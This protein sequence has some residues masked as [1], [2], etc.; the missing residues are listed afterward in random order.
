MLHRY[1]KNKVDQKPGWN[2]NMLKWCLQEARKH[3][4]KPQD[5][6]GGFV[7]DEM[8]IQVLMRNKI[9]ENF[10]LQQSATCVHD[11][12]NSNSGVLFSFF[13]SSSLYPGDTHVRGAGIRL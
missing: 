12:A 3:N 2:S 8:K 13:N 11:A 7:L 6:M 10:S 9:K 1:Y 5:Y 4:L